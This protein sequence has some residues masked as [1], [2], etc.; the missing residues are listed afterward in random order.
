VPTEAKEAF[1]RNI[2]RAEHFVRIHS[3]TQT[4]PGRPPAK[5][6]E[7]P[8]AAIVFAVGA[9]DAYI[10]EASAEYLVGRLE[11]GTAPKE[12]RELLSRI[13]RELPGLALEVVLMATAEERRGRMYET[14]VD[15]FHNNVSNHGSRAVSRFVERVGK[16]PPDFWSD[17]NQTWIDPPG[18]LDYYTDLRHEIVHQGRSPS[19]TRPEAK[20]FIQMLTDFIERLDPWAEE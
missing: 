13:D 11:G 16:K 19:V 4:K 18:V 14:V 2:A 9:L 7:L 17:L 5:M 3:D 12:L 20:K 10:S 1:E 6:A 15:H 8:R